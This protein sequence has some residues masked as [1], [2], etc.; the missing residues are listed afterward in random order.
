MIHLVEGPES[1]PSTPPV[2]EFAAEL[3]RSLHEALASGELTEDQR[4]GLLETLGCYLGDV[5]DSL[6]PRERDRPQLRLV[7]EVSRV[8]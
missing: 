1:R 4:L 3:G 7:R 8:G 6:R 5:E 2:V